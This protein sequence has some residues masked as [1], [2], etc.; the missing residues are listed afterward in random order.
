MEAG[1]DTAVRGRGVDPG[2][3]GRACADAK[4]AEEV[5]EE[6]QNQ[7]TWTWARFRGT[8]PAAAPAG[9][10]PAISVSVKATLD[11]VE[12]R[13]RHPFCRIQSCTTLR[14]RSDGQAHPH[15]H[16]RGSR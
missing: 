6:V 5:Q 16:V 7:L 3:S 11:P 9:I 1:L 13:D 10:E 12:L 14:S 2:E 8:V 15:T 4:P